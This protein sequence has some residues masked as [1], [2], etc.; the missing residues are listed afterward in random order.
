MS[1]KG[2]GL[3]FKGYVPGATTAMTLSHRSSDFELP[4]L[5]NIGGAYDYII[6]EKHKVTFAG[7]FTSNSFINDQFIGGIEYGF[8]NMFM[9]R[10]GY[11]YEKDITDDTKALTVFKGPSVG[12]T[13]EMPFNKENGSTFGIDYSYVS[14][15]NY[16]G[17]HSIGARINL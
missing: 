11:N 8:K 15:R 14:T 6:T 5:I 12:F 3:T 16:G 13:I 1:Y 10:A 2:D 9:V 7:N 4:S 17:C